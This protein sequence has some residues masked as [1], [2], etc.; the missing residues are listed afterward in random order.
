MLCAVVVVFAAL[1]S[2]GLAEVGS[3]MIDRQRAQTAADAAAL[4]GVRGGHS[5][6][7]A[8]AHRNG[9]TLLQF[10]RSGSSTVVVTVVVGVGSARARARAGDGP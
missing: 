10:S 4:A 1:V 3:A 7:A 9:G 8:F 5:A 6:A 2:L